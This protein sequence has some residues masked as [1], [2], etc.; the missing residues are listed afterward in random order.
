MCSGLFKIKSRLEAQIDSETGEIIS[1][2]K[3]WWNFLVV[4]IK[5]IEISESLGNQIA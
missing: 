5:P 2:E 1:L 4:K 3:Q